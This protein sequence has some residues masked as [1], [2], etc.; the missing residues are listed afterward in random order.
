MYDVFLYY[1]GSYT[2][3]V[4]WLFGPDG[5]WQLG[6]NTSV[7]WQYHPTVERLDS[8]PNAIALAKNYMAM[9]F[10]MATG[11]AFTDG[12][13]NPSFFLGQDIYFTET[14][15]ATI[16]N[17]NYDAVDIWSKSTN[18]SFTAYN[19]LYFSTE[20][21]MVDVDREIEISGTIDTNLLT[22]QGDGWTITYHIDDC[23]GKLQTP[24]GPN[25]IDQY[26]SNYWPGHDYSIN[27]KTQES[28]S[29]VF[30]NLATS[31]P[32]V[33]VDFD[34]TSPIT[35]T[36]TCNPSTTIELTIDGQISYFDDE[37]AMNA[38]LATIT[39]T[40]DEIYL[41]YY[42]REYG[43]PPTVEL[44]NGVNTLAVGA[45]VASSYTVTLLDY[46]GLNISDA[47][48]LSLVEVSLPHFRC[49]SHVFTVSP[50][51]IVMSK[52]DIVYAD[53]ESSSSSSGP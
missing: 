32:G 8:N 15:G 41:P 22:L 20:N 28:C 51:A 18:C 27:Q 1:R 43:S 16:N 53:C 9:E 40:A 45:A 14:W 48:S 30:Q 36:G 4:P 37:T 26:D 42:H 29:D 10:Y 50:I 5:R 25:T 13:P 38:W 2:Q 34:L 17:L 11:N 3:I 24:G 49:P 47:I 6:G 33:C 52:Q 35:P 7:G 12:S 21:Y 46:W 23:L 44:K 39:L 19:L 31:Y